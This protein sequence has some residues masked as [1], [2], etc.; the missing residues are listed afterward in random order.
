MKLGEKNDGLQAGIN[1]E[2]KSDEWCECEYKG[3]ENAWNLI[4]EI[5]NNLKEIED[6]PTIRTFLTMN[7]TKIVFFN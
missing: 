2:I 6:D 3:F 7:M 1:T 5:I 4:M